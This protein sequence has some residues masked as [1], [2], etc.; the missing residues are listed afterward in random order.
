[1]YPDYSDV[2]AA[3]INLST[4]HDYIYFKSEKTS[5]VRLR[6]SSKLIFAK[7]LGILGSCV[8]RVLCDLINV[9]LMFFCLFL[10]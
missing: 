7:L 5:A 6:I 8:L 4:T 9:R 1:M 2:R 10:W 3:H